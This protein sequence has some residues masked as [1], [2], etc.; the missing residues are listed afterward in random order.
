[1]IQSIE[2]LVDDVIGIEVDPIIGSNKKY[3][4]NDSIKTDH[5]YVNIKTSFEEKNGDVILEEY[6]VEKNGQIETYNNIDN[7]AARLVIEGLL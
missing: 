4:T 6:I 3:L 2:E 7:F 5:G 1:M